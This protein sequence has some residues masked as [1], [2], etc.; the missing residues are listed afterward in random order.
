[1]FK[2]TKAAISKTIDDIKNV[3]HF[4]GFL[5][6]FIQV[7]FGIY[8][9]A[10]DSGIFVV[11]LIML[12][13]ST[14]YCIL[15]LIAGK[16]YGGDDKEKK[17]KG[18]RVKA[19]GKQIIRWIKRPVQLYNFAV[20]IYG[21]FLF[22]PENLLFLPIKLLL[23]VFQIIFFIISLFIDLLV[24]IFER[25]K[26]FFEEAI[27]A[28]VNELKEPTRKTG[29]FFKKLV[30]KEPTPEP[31]QTRTER[32]LDEYIEE[33]NREKEQVKTTKKEEKRA[34]KQAKRL[35]KIAEKQAKKA[36]KNS[37]NSYEE[38]EAF[39]EDCMAVVVDS[40]K[41]VKEYLEEMGADVD[42]MSLEELE[43][44]S[45]VFALPDG[46]YLIVEG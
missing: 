20:I 9:L 34:E 23:I 12:I 43:E 7:P 45:E 29:N 1:M 5:L 17:K 6:A 44:A 42:G 31:E 24:I 33:Q 4:F 2:Y 41:E 28:D 40:L 39:L 8:N 25:R 32:I 15:Y 10:T 11:N 38:A 18:K 37:E 16:M 22:T 13:L 26:K 27:N 36:G 46:T 35:A 3:F 19:K 14:S 30:G 21:L